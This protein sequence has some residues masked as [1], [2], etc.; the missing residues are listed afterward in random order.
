MSLR[1]FYATCAIPKH[2]RAPKAPKPIVRVSTGM[3]GFEATRRHRKTLAIV[4]SKREIREQVRELDGYA[5]RWPDC[6][7]PLDTPW[8][9][10]EV[11]HQEAAGMGGDPNLE[12]YIIENLIALCKSHHRGDRGLHSPFARMAPL[13]P[14]L[15]MRGKVEFFESDGAEP[16]RWYSVGVTEPPKAA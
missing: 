5:C 9:A 6:S 12:R 16:P 3:K 1:E 14:I 8:G 7:V 11:A 13:D 4:R 10:L 15:R 2:Y